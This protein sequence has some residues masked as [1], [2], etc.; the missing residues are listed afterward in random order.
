MM[1]GL[2]SRQKIDREM[3]HPVQR[4]LL[5]DPDQQIRIAYLKQSFHGVVEPGQAQYLHG[6]SSVIGIH[7]TVESSVEQDISGLC[8]GAPG[9]TGLDEAACQHDGG[10]ALPVTMARAVRAAF[11]CFDTACNRPVL[12]R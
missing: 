4:I 5:S 12:M 3:P 8:A 2:R 7:V 1:D 10:V 6:A 11:Q 9:E